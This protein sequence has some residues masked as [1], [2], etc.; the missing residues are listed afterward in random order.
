VFLFPTSRCRQEE[1][2]KE[3]I[4][5]VGGKKGGIPNSQSKVGRGKGRKGEK[6]RGERGHPALLDS[7]NF[8]EGLGRGGGKGRERE[9]TPSY[10]A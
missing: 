6:K 3:G 10:G 5:R 2:R 9:M 1:G 7:P 4:E 8:P